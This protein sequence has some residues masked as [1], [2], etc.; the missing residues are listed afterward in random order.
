MYE[1]VTINMRFHL[2]KNHEKSSIKNLVIKDIQENPYQNRVIRSDE[3][4]KELAESIKVHGILQPILVRE[5]KG[6]HYLVSGERRMR[7]SVLAGMTTI[8]AVIREMTETEAASATL[9][10]NL[11]RE[12]VSYLDEA[13]GFYKLNKEF[14]LSQADIAKTI[15]KSQPYV[16]NKMRIL[17]LPEK[18][19]EIISRE[20][21]ITERHC[22]ALLKLPDEQMQLQLLHET[23]KKEL[24]TRQIEEKVEKIVN[25]SSKPGQNK[26]MIIKDIR[27]FLN[28]IKNAMEAL[29]ATGIDADWEQRDTED[30]YEFNI[31]IKK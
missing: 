11:Q 20:I 27:I 14:G 4:L 18:V 6:E 13:A 29:H 12:D 5:H 19:R 16:A 3:S 22:R 25:Q 26:R 9:V 23:I 1:D 7:A 28:S 30:F 8:P 31:R 2:L 17:N 24:S 10:E 21:M 15:G